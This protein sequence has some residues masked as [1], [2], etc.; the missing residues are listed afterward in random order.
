MGRRMVISRGGRRSELSALYVIQIMQIPLIAIGRL[1]R[2]W[3]VL[4]MKVTSFDFIFKKDRL[5]YN[6]GRKRSPLRDPP[7]T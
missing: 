3:R 5:K 6:R 2:C 7:K 1:G 4:C